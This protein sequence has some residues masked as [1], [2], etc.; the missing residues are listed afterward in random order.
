MRTPAWI[1]CGWFLSLV[2]TAA[3]DT[4][5]P[6]TTSESAGIRMEQLTFLGYDCTDGCRRHKAG[7]AWAEVRGIVDG[8]ACTDHDRSFMEGCLAFADAAQSPWA[9]GYAWAM[10]NE[11]GDASMCDGA[12]GSF[13]EGCREYCSGSPGL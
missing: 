1:V 3:E 9:T 13:A 7:F 10:A 11:V 6:A 5:G 8:G 4:P 2:T 12:G